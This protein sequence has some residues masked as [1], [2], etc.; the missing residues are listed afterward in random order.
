M[1][2]APARPPAGGRAEVARVKISTSMPRGRELAR[3]LDDVDVHAARVAG[4]WL[5][6]RRRVDAEHRHPLQRSRAPVDTRVRRLVDSIR[7]HTSMSRNNRRVSRIPAPPRLGAVPGR[8][9]CRRIECMTTARQSSPARAAASARPPPGAR[10]RW[11]PGRLRGPRR[12]RIERA[13]R[14][15]RR[16]GGRVRRHRSGRRSAA[17]PT[18]SGAVSTCWSTTPAAPSG[19]RPS[20]E[21]EAEDWQAMYDVNVLGTLQ[22]HPGAAARADRQRRRRA[23]QHGLDGRPRSRTKA[24]AATRLPSTASR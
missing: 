5:V 19:R 20:A 13:G 21:A 15:D 14:R 23:D 7:V 11:L 22:R 6:E 2:P 24:A 12:E 10:R 8:K 18:R 1:T 9:T 16:P 4:A 3:Q 17:W